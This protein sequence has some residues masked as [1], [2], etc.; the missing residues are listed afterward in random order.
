MIPLLANQE[1]LDQPGSSSNTTTTT[2]SNNWA[3]GPDG[4]R[5]PPWR[6]G[7]PGGGGGAGLPGHLGPGGTISEIEEG[8]TAPAPAP[9]I[10]PAAAATA[11]G[12]GVQH[13]HYHLGDGR[14][15]GGHRH[16]RHPGRY[17]AE[18]A[19][20]AAAVAAAAYEGGARERERRDGFLGLVDR[21]RDREMDRHVINQDALNAREART[22]ALL[23]RERDRDR[24]GV[25]VVGLLGRELDRRRG[26]RPGGDAGGR[27][28]GGDGGDTGGGDERLAGGLRSEI[29]ALRKDLSR[30]TTGGGGKASKKAKGRREK[31]GADTGRDRGRRAASRSPRRQTTAA[32]GN[33]NITFGGRTDTDDQDSED[34]EEDQDEESDDG[35]GSDVTLPRDWARASGQDVRARGRS[36]R[37]PGSP[38]ES[39]D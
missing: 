12:H 20:A 11:G 5:D 22:L 17:G 39:P 7:G 13:H 31:S 25:D 1:S 35:H 18:D 32:V 2:N 14:G 29:E 26:V 8:R 30:L 24:G 21:E 38:S 15:R 10:T 37:R 19:A 23:D 28:D 6:Y 33:S 3:Y 36:L 34:D 9:A 16:G 27:D 4:W